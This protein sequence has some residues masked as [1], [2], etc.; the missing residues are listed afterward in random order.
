MRSKEGHSKAISDADQLCSMPT[1]NMPLPFSAGTATCDFYSF[2]AAIVNEIAHCSQSGAGGYYVNYILQQPEGRHVMFPRLLDETMTCINASDWDD[3]RDRVFRIITGLNQ[4]TNERDQ[5]VKRFIALM[6][7]PPK[8]PFEPSKILTVYHNL[9]GN[10]AKTASALSPLG[11]EDYRTLQEICDLAT[12]SDGMATHAPVMQ[13][14]TIMQAI[15]LRHPFP[16]ANPFMGRILFSWSCHESGIPLMG[17]MPIAQI[18]TLLKHSKELFPKSKQ[19]S[20]NT[21]LKGADWTPWLEEVLKRL[22]SEL[23][24]FS[25]KL[26]GLF[27]RRMRMRYLISLDKDFNPRQKSIILEALVHPDAEFTYGSV[28]ERFSVAYAT[29]YNDLGTLEAEGL[30][31]ADAR[32]KTTVFIATKNIRNVLHSYLSA[33]LP[34]EYAHFYNEKGHLSSAYLE[35]HKEMIERIKK[36]A[37]LTAVGL[38]DCHLPLYDLPRCETLLNE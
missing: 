17:I 13:A 6:R 9:L 3:K 12:S 22:S 24:R 15:L 36:T 32:R 7:T 35:S 8:G 33:A 1:Y 34:E 23:D 4:P 20:A 10:S 29:A 25:V 14:V 26:Y 27:A 37:S 19:L 5:L 2:N 31:Q 21:A 18:V 16:L 30:L 38:F 11:K 28:V